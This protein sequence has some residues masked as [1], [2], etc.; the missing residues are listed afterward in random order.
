[1]DINLCLEFKYLNI[2]Q[3]FVIS[4]FF[5]WIINYLLNFDIKKRCYFSKGFIIQMLLF[6]NFKNFLYVQFGDILIYF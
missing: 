5:F 6:E 4:Q 2:C 3:V 1:M